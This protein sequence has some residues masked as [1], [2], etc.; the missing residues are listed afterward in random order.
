MSV[1][2]Q[3]R[4]A[5]WSDLLAIPESER[6][7]EVIDGELVRKAVPS[8]RHG[9]AQAQ[10]VVEIGGP[11][12]RRGRGGPGGWRFA[13]EVEIQ[14]EDHQIYRPDVAGWL[15]ERLPELPAEVPIL[16]RPDWVCELLSPSN[17]QN[18]LVKKMRTYRRCRV[19]H[20][21]IIDP[22]A[23]TLQAY[24]W[25]PDGY[26]LV[27]AAQGDDPV[28]AEP[29]REVTFSVRSLIAGDDGE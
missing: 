26:L 22:L 15:R 8:A 11:Y 4:E 1:A 24:R 5:S 9:G 18:D 17:A 28:Q 6:F 23:E 14:F 13:T 10:L 19:P 20:Y 3:A 16:V 25:T 12:G 27:E 21:W 29:F 2:P 7:H